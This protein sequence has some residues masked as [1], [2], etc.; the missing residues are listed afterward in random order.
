MD[1][2]DIAKN[3]ANVQET[4]GY[5]LNL[6]G[7]INL[8]QISIRYRSAMASIDNLKTA[9]KEVQRKLE[10]DG[11]EMRLANFLNKTATLQ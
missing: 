3:Y 9:D 4:L 7:E 5:L 8:L 10:V 11:L 2:A 1:A 6:E